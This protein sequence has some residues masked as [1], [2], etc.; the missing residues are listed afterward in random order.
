MITVLNSPLVKTFCPPPAR[1]LWDRK[2]GRFID[3]RFWY[4]RALVPASI[5]FGAAVAWFFVFAIIEAVKALL[6]LIHWRAS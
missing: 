1:A 6:D 4:V 5:I 2:A 3:S